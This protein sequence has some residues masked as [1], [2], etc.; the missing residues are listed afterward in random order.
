MLPADKARRYLSLRLPK[1][2]VQADE[3]KGDAE[4]L[5]GAEHIAES[6]L[7][8]ALT[9]F[10]VFPHKAHAPDEHQKEPKEVAGFVAFVGF[11]VG[12]EEHGED[13]EIADG[14]VQL[15]RMAGYHAQLGAHVVEA[16]FDAGGGDLSALFAFHPGVAGG[17]FEQETDAAVGGFAYNFGVHEIAEADEAAGQRGGHHNFVQYPEDGFFG[18]GAR[19]NPHGQYD[20]DGAAVTGQAALPDFE[21]FAG[22]LRVVIPVVEEDVPEARAQHRAGYHI[23]EALVEPGFR[24]IFG[25]KHA[26]HHEQAQ[27]EPQCE[28]QSVPAQRERPQFGYFGEDVPGN[29]GECRHGYVV[30][31]ALT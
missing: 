24:R 11:P 27:Q 15:H 29:V 8:A 20:A 9:H 3:Y 25:Q 12:V 10:E 19:E 2:K 26:A 30:L 17:V 4:Q 6:A 22:M 18:D 1:H 28:E 13:E 14:F 7:E 31:R 21:H 23:D 5:P 16:R